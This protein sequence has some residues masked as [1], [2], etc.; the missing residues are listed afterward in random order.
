MK[1]HAGQV[2]KGSGL[3]Y[4]FHCFGGV[5]TLARWGVK[6]ELIW[7]IMLL[8][9]AKEDNPLITDEEIR[10]CIGDTGLRIINELTHDSSKETKDDYMKS[11]MFKSYLSLV[12]KLADRVN[13]TLDYYY[14]EKT[15]KY[16]KEYWKKAEQLIKDINGRANEL[17]S[18]LGRRVVDNMLAEIKYV[19]SLLA[20]IGD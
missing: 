1:A 10:E 3:P 14:E 11:F 8:H 13:N 7:D 9:D 19:E 18:M 2:R 17:A 5:N 6:N 12:C 16:S 4:V 15:M 20:G